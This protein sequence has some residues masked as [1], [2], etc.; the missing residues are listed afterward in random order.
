MGTRKINKKENLSRPPTLGLPRR[1]G[2]KRDRFWR[3]HI[4]STVVDLRSIKAKVSVSKAPRISKD[5]QKSHAGLPA[6]GYV[7]IV[8]KYVNSKKSIRTRLA[9]ARREG[10]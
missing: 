4:D 3:R 9:L 8:K 1:D 10:I 7:D 5:I 2:P 6:N